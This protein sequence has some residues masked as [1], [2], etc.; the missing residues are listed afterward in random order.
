MV[1]EFHDLVQY[2]RS[3]E[4]LLRWAEMS[5]FSDM[6]M[7]THPGVKP[8]LMYQIYDDPETLAIYSSI[9]KMHVSLKSYKM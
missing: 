4:L 9:V 8:D 1:S 3:K 5:C 2:K 7:R 6:I